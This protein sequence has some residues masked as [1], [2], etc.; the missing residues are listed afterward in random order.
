MLNH[1]IT[2]DVAALCHPKSLIAKDVFIKSSWLLSRAVLLID[3]NKMIGIHSSISH[4]T[5][6]VD[7]VINI[8]ITDYIAT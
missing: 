2:V 1:V 5:R 4:V 8:I 3:P 6:S 7:T